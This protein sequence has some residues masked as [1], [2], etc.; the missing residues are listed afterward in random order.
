MRKGYK[1]HNF[2]PEGRPD[3]P[4]YQDDPVFK[5]CPHCEGNIEEME[6]CTMCEGTGEVV[7]EEPYSYL[8]D[9]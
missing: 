1:K 3:N 2:D 5:T 8:E 6:D 7:D 4:C 9:D